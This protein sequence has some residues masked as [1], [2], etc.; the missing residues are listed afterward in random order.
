MRGQRWLDLL[1]SLTSTC[2]GATGVKVTAAP[3]SK[4]FSVHYSL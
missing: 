2:G 3:T 1:I 4:L